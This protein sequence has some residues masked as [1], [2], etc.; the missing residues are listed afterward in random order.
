MARRRAAEEE[1]AEGEGEAGWRRGGVRRWV[2]MDA[3]EVF[4]RAG[5]FGAAAAG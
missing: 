1:E 3:R 2:A 5:R 4:D